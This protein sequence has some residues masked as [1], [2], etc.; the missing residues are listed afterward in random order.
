[1]AGVSF[2]LL[3]SLS[4][5]IIGISENLLIHFFTL[6]RYKSYIIFFS[7]LSTIYSNFEKLETILFMFLFY[8]IYFITIR[9]SIIYYNAFYNF[10]IIYFILTIVLFFFF[11]FLW[12]KNITK[13]AINYE[14]LY[15]MLLSLL[16]ILNFS[17]NLIFILLILES[18]AAIYYFFFLKYTSYSLTSFIKYKNLL[19]L[20]LWLSFFTLMFFIVGLVFIVYTY[21]TL[22]I[23]ELK[24]TNFN[25]GNN[26]LLFSIFIKIGVPGFHFLKLEI[27]KFLNLTEVIFFSLITLLI[28]TMFICNFFFLN[29]LLLQNTLSIICLVLLFNILL[30]LQGMEGVNFN[31]FLALSSFTTITTFIIIL[32]NKC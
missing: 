8:S 12:K 22:N 20:Y 4:F 13:F 28:N 2:T 29:N 17:D 19:S 3:W 26:I 30:L 27:Y 32:M 25:S 1:M 24:A 16:I 6:Y 23:F 11:K 31:H 14:Y 15:I 10:Y 9:S 18:I 5:F 21:G 7:K